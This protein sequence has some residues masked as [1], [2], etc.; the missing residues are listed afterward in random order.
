MLSSPQRSQTDVSGRKDKID[1]KATVIVKAIGLAYLFSTQ[2]MAT[3][4]ADDKALSFN[5]RGACKFLLLHV[6][7]VLDAWPVKQAWCPDA[8]RQGLPARTGIQQETRQRERIL[9]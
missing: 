4:A 3:P 8:V 7:S 1:M 9:L 6:P 2:G 5:E